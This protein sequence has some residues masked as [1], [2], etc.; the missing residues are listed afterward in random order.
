MSFDRLINILRQAQSRY[1]GFARRFEEA[2]ALGRWPVAVGPA[3]A[4]H[5]RAMKVQDS[6]LWVEVDHP[7]WKSELHHRKHQILAILNQGHPDEAPSGTAPPVKRAV[8]IASPKR[9]LAPATETLKDLW[10]IDRMG[11]RG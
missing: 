9:R 5:T 2:E 3:I 6:V 4:K 11:P 10:F 7:I 1:P 8:V